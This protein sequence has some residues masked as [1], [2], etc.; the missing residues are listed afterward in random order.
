MS[1][2]VF[3]SCTFLR[4]GLETQ[5]QTYFLVNKIMTLECIPFVII[6]KYTCFNHYF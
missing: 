5:I 1:I 6:L 2:F 4:L 3:T